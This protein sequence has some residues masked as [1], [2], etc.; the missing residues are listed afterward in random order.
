MVVTTVC[1]SVYVFS[2]LLSLVQFVLTGNSSTSRVT[3]D[4]VNL[5][6]SSSISIS[7]LVVVENF[8]FG[9]FFDNFSPLGA[10]VSA[11]GNVFRL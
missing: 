4:L 11:I 3:L 2:L 7:S 6:F 10:L 9:L 1:C 8:S 5:E